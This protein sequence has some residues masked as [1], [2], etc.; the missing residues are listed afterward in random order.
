MNNYN[1]YLLYNENI[2]RTYIGI[3]NNLE[4][5]LYQHNAGKG[6][7]C[8]RMYKNW[9]YYKIINN[10]TKSEALKVEYKWKKL[11]GFKNRKNFMI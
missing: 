7:K 9:I 8:T 10:L 1:C 6:A 3:T 5:R 2:N 4:K 11:K